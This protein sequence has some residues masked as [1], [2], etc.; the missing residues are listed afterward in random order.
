MQLLSIGYPQ[1]LLKDVL[2]ALPW[3]VCLLFNQTVAAT[4][5]QSN[6]DVPTSPIAVTL[7][8]GQALVCGAFVVANAAAVVTLK[9]I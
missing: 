4:I 6:D 7:V 9:P 5:S 3:R 2:Y 8:D 1:T